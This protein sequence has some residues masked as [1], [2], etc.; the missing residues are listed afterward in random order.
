MALLQVR[1]YGDR[2]AGRL[3]RVAQL[4]S[5]TPDPWA[6]WEPLGPGW[7]PCCLGGGGGK[8]SGDSALPLL[9]LFGLASVW[10]R[11]GGG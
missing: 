1:R 10:G 6:P 9:A 5:D 4:E 2:E 11:I 3:A 7:F 8:A